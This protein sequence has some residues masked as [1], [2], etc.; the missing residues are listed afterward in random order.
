M[1]SRLHPF[2][3]LAFLLFLL[4]GLSSRFG[5]GAY[6]Q[7]NATPLP[8]AKY[9]FVLVHI[10]LSEALNEL[11]DKTNI[12]IFYESEL[13]Q[14]K[15]T[16]CNIE[17][18]SA[19]EALSCIL[20][21]AKLDFYQQS[22]GLYVITLPKR[23]APL[24]GSLTGIVVDLNTNEP[25]PYASIFLEEASTGAASNIEGRFAFS[26]LKPGRYRVYTSH[27][28]Y[29]DSADS[30]YV[31]PA[32]HHLM[33]IKMAPKTV[34]TTPIVINGLNQRLPSKEL[35][36]VR[37]SA[38][39]LQNAPASSTPSTLQAL[40]AV[41]GVHVGDA[42]AD[43]HVQG[44]DSGEHQYLLD[45]AP[46]FIPI[47]NG[48]FFGSFSPFAINQVTVHKA[49]FEA[50]HGSYL[51]GS[52]E[53]NHDLQSSDGSIATIQIDPLSLNGRL[54]GKI[55]EEKNISAQW[56][57]AG[58]FG[59]W[60]VFQ[61]NQIEQNFRDW[62]RPNT[63][64]ANTLTSTA[65]DPTLNPAN[66]ADS[67]LQMSFSDIHAATRIR[68]GHARSIYASLYS[69]N[70]EFGIGT[71]PFTGISFSDSSGASRS[72]D[73][74]DRP[75]EAYSWSNRMSQIRYEWVQGNRTFLKA[76]LWSTKYKLKHPFEDSPFLSS[77]QLTTRTDSS[78][79]EEL[80]DDFNEIREFGIQLGI[81]W[82][83]S[84]RHIISANAQLINTESEFR[85]SIDPLASSLS[86]TDRQLQPI[87]WRLQSFVEDAISLSK[88][89]RVTLG[90]RFTYIPL[91]KR[92]YAEPRISVRRDFVRENGQIWA[93]QLAAGLYR[94]FINQFDVASYNSSALLPSFRFWIPVNKTTRA[95]SAYHTA[96]SLLFIP[97]ESV[98]INLEGYYKYHPNLT[99]LD[100]T[101][102]LNNTI[103]HTANSFLQ[104]ASGYSYGLGLSLAYKLDHL[105]LR[106]NYDYAIARRKQRNR[107]DDRFVP[108]P[109]ETPHQLHAIV[110]YTLV[111]QLTL[112]IRWQG[113]FSRSWGY[114]RAY[115]DYLE[116][117]P[118]LVSLQT[119]NLSEPENQKLPAF[120]QWDLGIA[121]SHQIGHTGIQGRLNFVNVF[122]ESNVIDWILVSDS[123]GNT[124]RASRKSIAFFP[125]ASLKLSF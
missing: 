116:P 31:D 24:H 98:Q 87:S 54:N 10:P 94:Q 114:R 45:D 6:A 4:I 48:G 111:N 65:E 77:S 8:E 19:K 107:F 37:I 109:W 70:N 51:S 25:L 62:S 125:S 68:F 100:Y 30:L 52:I 76:G 97:N 119:L 92:L 89:T 11:I 66:F 36:A 27:V 95:S 3:K 88:D 75:A 60:D 23:E 106:T 9:S 84:A 39:E 120:T 49:G 16:Y 81:D 102:R 38:G 78:F 103:A 63:F 26:R 44:G 34:L 33:E 124:I 20:T 73:D 29:E 18:A 91:Q 79:T 57:V 2:S 5:A 35:S 112:T 32:G 82:A 105:H 41:A 13:I 47:R 21:S 43:V 99:L 67:L 74:D 40:D 101:T 115:Y 14:E 28:A 110:D 117:D 72:L 56:M 122:N 55:R 7:K 83:P 93:V 69:G 104:N 80:S 12:D 22:S 59:L 96:A 121:Y 85:L 46:I 61:P 50:R 53:F 118:S 15:T 17:N 58:R 64:L 113:L 90:S 86:I 123:N 71:I 1:L 42:L 108:V